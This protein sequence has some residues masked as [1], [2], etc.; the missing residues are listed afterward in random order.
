MGLRELLAI[1]GKSC[2]GRAGC[3]FSI[4]LVIISCHDL[5]FRVPDLWFSGYQFSLVFVCLARAPLPSLLQPPLRVGAEVVVVV[6][7]VRA[8]KWRSR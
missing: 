5:R 6:A 7:V 2:E 3:G 8:G 4:Y 1:G